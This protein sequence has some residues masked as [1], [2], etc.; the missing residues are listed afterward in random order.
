MIDL[1]CHILPGID[2]GA[3][4]LEESITMCH[5][6]YNDGIRTIVASPHTMNGIFINERDFIIT[7]VKKFQKI[8]IT[9]K[10]D[11]HII[12]GADV[13]VNYNLLE[14]IRDGK[15]MTINDHGKY[16]LL[17]LP[18]QYVPPKIPEFVFKLKLNKITPIFTHPE[19]NIAIQKDL[20]IILR[21]VE[22]GALTQITASSLIGGFGPRA[23]N[24]A[25][26]ML[27]YN[28]AHILASDAHS[29]KFRPPILSHSISKAAQI[30]DQKWAEAMVTTI[31]QAIIN[32][33]NIDDLPKP[34]APQKSILKRI[35]G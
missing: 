26:E 27:R 10:I 29:S 9:K 13:H 22:Q 32:G 1:H 14:L 12:P 20:N 24:C 35:F 11:I 19:R 18:H 31:P 6:A 33:E 23:C 4:N 25:V 34:V 15:A 7:E 5:T 17:E 28:L 16:I 3:E 21:L 8:L 30:T 2:D